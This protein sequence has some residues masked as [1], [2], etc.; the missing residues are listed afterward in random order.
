M[1]NALDPRIR[2]AT[3]PP[4]Q[5]DYEGLQ[6]KADDGLHVKPVENYPEVVHYSD[7]EVLPDRISKLPRQRTCRL[8]RRVFIALV[9][10]IVLLVVGGGVAM[11]IAAKKSQSPSAYENWIFSDVYLC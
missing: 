9:V 11:A 4:R 3:M 2:T 6:V 5:P 1:V 7:K 8:T 10:L